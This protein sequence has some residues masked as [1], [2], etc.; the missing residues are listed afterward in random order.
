MIVHLNTRPLM[1]QFSLIPLD[2][3][4]LRS[5]SRITVAMIKAALIFNNHGKPRLTKFFTYYTEEMQQQV[6]Q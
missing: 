2:F 4:E 6:F 3:S 5:Y 1:N